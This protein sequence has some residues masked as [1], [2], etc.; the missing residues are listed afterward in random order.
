MLQTEYSFM[1]PRGYVDDDGMLHRAGK[2]RLATA[3]DEILPLRDP[4]VRDNAE[5][6]SI[7]ILSRVVTSIGTLPAIDASIIERL[8]LPDLACLQDLYNRI[9]QM[10][11]PCY[12]EHCPACGQ[13]VIIPI[14]FQQAGR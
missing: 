13:K 1:L 5:Y 8:F 14:N 3:A 12:E 11:N 2:M 10:E 7:L 6:M 9:N 4:R